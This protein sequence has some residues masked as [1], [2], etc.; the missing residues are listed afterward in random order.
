MSKRDERME[1]HW[2]PLK[3][4]PNYSVSN[5][6]NVAN[7]RTGHDLN[8]TKRT[9]GRLMVSL[10]RRRDGKKQRTSMYV[11]ILVAMAF[12]PEYRKGMQVYHINGVFHDNAVINLTLNQIKEER[13]LPAIRC[14]H[15]FRHGEHNHTTSVTTPDGKLHENIVVW[16]DG[17]GDK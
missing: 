16:C 17:K 4:W 7:N 5:Y 1:E 3:G 9:D 8:P 2:V 11:H 10:Y 15:R 12:F 14:R 13:M 6:G